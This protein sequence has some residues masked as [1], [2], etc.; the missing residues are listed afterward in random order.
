MAKKSSGRGRPKKEDTRKSRDQI[1]DSA[2]RLFADRGFYRV[3]L[4]DITAHA[5]V[6][7]ALV[8]YY[9]KNKSGLLH[10]VFER[11]AVPIIAERHQLLDECIAHAG[12]HGRPDIGEVLSAF[13]GPIMLPRGPA[14]DSGIMQR[15]FGM[16]L[17]DP[18]PEVR[19]A[20]HHNYH[21]IA[22]RFIGI[23][24]RACPE[25]DEQE[26]YWRITC[27]FGAIIYLFAQPGRVQRMIKHDF[28][29]TDT[30]AAFGY[31]IPFLEAGMSQPPTSMARVKLS[32]SKARKSA[33]DIVPTGMAHIDS[34]R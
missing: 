6:N 33:L 16:G 12:V 31:V 7:V 34:K 4:R 22:V 27:V 30:E 17:S 10:A 5:G 18:S 9:F 2:E 19:R 24:R 25:L 29:D 14:R 1:L 3:S 21:D 20:I 8:N 11:R 26:F 32:V 13:I 23:L 28:D 15:L